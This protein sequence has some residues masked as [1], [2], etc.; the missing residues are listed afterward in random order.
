MSEV[1]FEHNQLRGITIKNMIVTIVCTASIV[2]SVMTTYFNLKSGQDAIQY[3][4]DKQNIVT[5][6]RLRAIE[7]QIVVINKQIEE[8]QKDKK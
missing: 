5:D 1:G 6:L 3:T 7:A 4:Q 2:V 8:L